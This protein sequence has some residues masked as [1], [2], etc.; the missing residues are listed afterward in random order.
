MDMKTV[1]TNLTFTNV[2]VVICSI[3]MVL[4]WIIIGTALESGVKSAVTDESREVLLTIIEKSDQDYTVLDDV[5]NRW[6][7]REKQVYWNISVG[8]PFRAVIRDRLHQDDP[9]AG[10]IDA[11]LVEVR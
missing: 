10:V 7:V 1:R 11:I 2:V 9:Y 8:K 5:G 6:R 4:C 3:G